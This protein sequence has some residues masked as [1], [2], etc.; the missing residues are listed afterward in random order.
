MRR[1]DE[2]AAENDPERDR[3][4]AEFGGENGAYNRSCTGNCGEMVT[5]EH[6]RMGGDEVDTVFLSMRRGRS[7]RV[8]PK[9]L[10]EFTSIKKVAP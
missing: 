5:E 9:H 6:G 10:F 8:D 7:R 4:P 2:D 3:R 1:A